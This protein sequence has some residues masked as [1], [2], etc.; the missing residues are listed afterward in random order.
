VQG[1]I[2]AKVYNGGTLMERGS[3]SRCLNRRS[4]T[5]TNIKSLAIAALAVG[6]MAMAATQV[7]AA[8]TATEFAKAR[9]AAFGSGNVNALMDQYT[10]DATLFSPGGVLHGKAEIRTMLESVVAEFGQPGVRFEL[11]S[12]AAVGDTVAFVWKAETA[13]AVY[14]LG[15]ETYVLAGGKA[16]QQTLVLATTPK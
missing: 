5:M 7:E 12:Q 1:T 6:G 9:L 4:T 3:G 10:D 8:N 11:V 14:D 15:V 2:F 16:A 13:K